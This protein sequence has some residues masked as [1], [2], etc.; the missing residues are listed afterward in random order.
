M[1]QHDE[2]TSEGRLFTLAEATALIPQLKTVLSKAKNG[3]MVLI[4]TKDEVKKACANSEYGGGT[5]VGPQYVNALEGM[6]ESLETIQEMGVIVKDL[7]S[8]LCDFPF[9]LDGRIVY[10]CWKLGEDKIEWWHEI[11]SGFSGRQAIPKNAQ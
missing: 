9:L 6:H 5:V 2:D 4:Q 1:A 11:T 3:R 8:G 10:L 7:E